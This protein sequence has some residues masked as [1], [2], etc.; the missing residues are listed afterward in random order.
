MSAEPVRTPMTRVEATAATRERIARGAHRLFFERPYEDVTLLDIAEAG[1]VSHQTVLNHFESKEGV[2]LAVFEIVKE[3]TEAARYN[4]QPGDV[5]GAMKALIG[6]YERM[7]DTNIGWL[8]T[9]LRFERVAEALE[10]GRASHREWIE[11]IFAKWLPTARAARQRAINTLHAATDVY[12]WKLLRRDLQLSRAETERIM[13]DLVSGV[14][15]GL[16]R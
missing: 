8:A 16:R 15:K 9:A 10:I 3:Q 11:A 12:I 13:T 14:L 2:A 1:G 4:A 6:E 5:R 7:G